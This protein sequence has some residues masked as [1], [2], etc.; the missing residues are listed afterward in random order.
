MGTMSVSEAIRAFSVEVIVAFPDSNDNRVL[1]EGMEKGT[2]FFQPIV[3]SSN[4]D[5]AYVA[6]ALMGA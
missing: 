4:A 2:N 6:D 3:K 5:A 1:A